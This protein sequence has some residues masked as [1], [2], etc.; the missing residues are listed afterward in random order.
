MTCNPQQIL[1]TL[2]SYKMVCTSAVEVIKSF[3][4]AENVWCNPFQIQ[5]EEDNCNNQINTGNELY[6]LK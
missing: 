3:V 5:M 6:F 1:A 2:T 4:E